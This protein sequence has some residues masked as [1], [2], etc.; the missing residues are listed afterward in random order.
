[1]ANIGTP[2]LQELARAADSDDIRDQ[3]VVL[4]SKEVVEDTEKMENYR[5]LRNGVRMRDRYIRELRTSAMSDEVVQSIKI[6][7]WVQVDDMEKA[8]RLLLMAREI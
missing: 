7:K 1:M 8:S 3:L 6:L 5:Q 2:L 4:F